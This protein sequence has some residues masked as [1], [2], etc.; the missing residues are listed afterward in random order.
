MLWRVRARIST[1]VNHEW[2]TAARKQTGLQDSELI[3]LA[4]SA[5]LE[6]AEREAEDRAL[7]ETPYELDADLAS[8]PTGWPAEASPLDQYDGAV[9][10]DVVALFAAR[11]RP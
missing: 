4:L 3:D 8:L 11:K 5:L 10:D 6:R 9:P 7:S 1:T 2:L